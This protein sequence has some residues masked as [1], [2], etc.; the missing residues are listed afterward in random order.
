MN[1]AELQV[2]VGSLQGI[3]EEMGAALIRSAFS[4]NIKERQDCSTALFDA[5]GRLVMQAEHIPV[6]LGAMPASVDAVRKRDPAPGDVWCLNDPF[7]GG[8]HLP[9]ITLVSPIHVDGT[10]VG[11]AASR[12]HHADVGGMTPASMPADSRDLQQ[13][14]L[15]IPADPARERAGV[16]RPPDAHQR[17]Q[18][19]A[20][21]AHRRPASPACGSPFGR[22]S[23]GRAVLGARCGVGPAGVS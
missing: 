3:A 11:F 20:G 12:A 14:G 2:A 22:A 16:D 19:D 10:H 17:Q 4:P 13:E 6:H 5:D 8:W 21:G 23:H 15:V 9:D 7:A 1:A 18:P